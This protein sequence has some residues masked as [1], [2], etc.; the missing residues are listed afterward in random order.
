MLGAVGDG[1]LV[2]RWRDLGPVLWLVAAGAGMLWAALLGA[3]AFATRCRSIEPGPPTLDPGGP[4][5]AA[6]V[7]LITDE[8][9]LGHEAV[10]ATLLDLAARRLV[11]IDQ[12]GERTLVTV[13]RDSARTREMAAELEPYERM[14]LDHVAAHATDGV[15][16]AEALTTGPEEEARGWWKSFRRSVE[17]DAR[18]R[19]LSRRRWSAGVRIALALS[20][21][22]VA[23]LVGLAASTL[24]D[25]PDDPDD[26]PVSA[27]VAFAVVT[28]GAL[29]AAAEALNGQRD[30]PAGREAARKWLGLRAMLAEDPL[31]AEHPPAGVA[32]WD[33]LLA[34]GAAMGVAHGAVRALPLGA[35]SDDEAWSPLGGHWRVV[36]IR[37]PRFFPPGYG[38]HPARVAAIGLL[39]LGLAALA[40]PAAVSAADALRDLV[41]DVSADDT[42]PAGVGVGI[43]V[44]LG[45]VVALA[46]VLAVRGALMALSGIAD[47]VTPRRTVEGRVVR[48]RRRGDDEHPR[49][50]VAVDQGTGNRATAWRTM[51]GGAVQGSTVRAEVTRW[52]GHVR[53][54]KV[55]T[56]APARPSLPDDGED[57]PDDASPLS[58]LLGTLAPTGAGRRQH[59]RRPEVPT[60]A[61]PPPPLP[62]ASVV[63][64]ATGRSLELDPAAAPHPLAADGRS[65]A[66][67][68]PDG[69]LIQVAWVD[70]SLLQ[71]HRSMPRILRRELPGV[72]DEAYRA[73]IGGGVVARRGGHVLMVMGRMAGSSDEER[74]QAFEAI[75]RSALG[76]PPG[77]DH[78]GRGGP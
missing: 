30:T 40:R 7:N 35:E 59:G 1:S 36:R 57:D 58:S 72:G 15:V 75:A 14:V 6:V 65:A 26:D 34:Y 70:S 76:R 48:V 11:T 38:R 33:R 68:A 17:R 43:S 53:D 64:A 44:V 37:Y 41:V 71:A 13:R 32:I 69:T 9:R 18:R 54:L 10:P 12:V 4:E 78:A 77:V 27:A 49:W 22:V 51:P 55:V 42:V 61:G 8:W 67:A 31:F 25:N 28:A 74:N 56:R 62:D 50:Y 45:L 73:V 20:A 60:A 24:P 46:L 16:P 47:L 63:A 3:F 23:L 52:L 39:Q 5:P 19:G 66:F 2:E 21:V 29:M